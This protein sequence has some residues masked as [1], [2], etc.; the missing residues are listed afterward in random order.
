MATTATK[1]EGN[2]LVYIFAYILTWL[3][4]IIV[5][6]TEGQHDKRAKFHALQAIF[7]GIII[8]I[9]YLIPLPFFYILAILLWIYGIYVG[10]KAYDG[11][12]VMIPV[13][14]DYAKKYSGGHAASTA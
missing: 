11:K 4:G 12:D 9:V 8:F 5:Y 7:L 3:S 10:V 14:G 2:R 13:L 6:V 1:K